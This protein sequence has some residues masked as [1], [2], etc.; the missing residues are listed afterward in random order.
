LRAQGF[1]KSRARY[2]SACDIYEG[3]KH[4]E[5]VGSAFSGNKDFPSIF[6]MFESQTSLKNSG[7]TQLITP[8]L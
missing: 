4:N 7:I 2:G 8:K 6:G 3:D 1:E 5:K